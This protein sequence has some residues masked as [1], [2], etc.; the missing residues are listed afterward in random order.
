MIIWQ[1]GKFFKDCRDRRINKE[2]TKAQKARLIE[3]ETK[4]D[5]GQ[6]LMDEFAKKIET[7]GPELTMREDFVIS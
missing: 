5:S 2:S 1:F 7:S 6:P 3:F 4:L